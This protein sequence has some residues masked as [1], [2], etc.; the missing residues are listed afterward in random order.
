MSIAIG[1][2]INT[3]APSLQNEAKNAAP[4]DTKAFTKQPERLYVETTGDVVVENCFGQTVTFANAQAGTYIDIIVC[5]ILTASTATVKIMGPS[6][7][8]QI[9]TIVTALV[10]DEAPANTLDDGSGNELISDG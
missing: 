1:I 10:D 9:Q 4:S 7:L 2:G 3:D 8:P 6:A 5:K